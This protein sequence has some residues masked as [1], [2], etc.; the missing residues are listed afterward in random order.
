PCRAKPPSARAM[1]A[2]T[3]G[4]SAMISDFDMGG[5][6]KERQIVQKS[7]RRGQE[8]DRS[9]RAKARACARV[10][11]QANAR[12]RLRLP[13]AARKRRCASR[14]LERSERGRDRLRREPASRGDGIDA[15]RRVSHG[16]DHRTLVR[17]ELVVGRCLGE[18]APCLRTDREPKL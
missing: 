4:F 11:A 1:S 10:R 12:L 6:A 5:G 17:G 14:D 18:G 7:P 8:N 13:E 16:G 2:A 15:G 9:R 3:E